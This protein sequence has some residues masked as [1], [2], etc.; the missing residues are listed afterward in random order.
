ML[1]DFLDIHT[2][3]QTV[4]N[5]N[6]EVLHHSQGADRLLLIPR[7]HRRQVDPQPKKYIIFNLKPQVLFLCHNLQFLVMLHILDQ[8]LWKVLF[9][10]CEQDFFCKLFCLS[11]LAVSLTI[12]VSF[13]FS[14]FSRTIF[15]MKMF[16]GS[17]QFDA[18][19]S[20]KI[21]SLC[22]LHLFGSVSKMFKNIALV[23]RF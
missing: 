5:R 10:K 7:F 14:L 20:S 16:C 4:L 2:N 22:T 13:Y 23:N 6:K 12:S 15:V 1:T 21:V 3:K 11:V 17:Q 8:P 19:D 18:H 9:Q